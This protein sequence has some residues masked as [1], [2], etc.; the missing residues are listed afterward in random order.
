MTSLTAISV[1]NAI[2]T[3]LEGFQRL[4]TPLDVPVSKTMLRVNFVPRIIGN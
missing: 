2:E 1:A 4:I 3:L